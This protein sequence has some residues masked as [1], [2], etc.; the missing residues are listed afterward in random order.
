MTAVAAVLGA[1]FL[2]ATL[3]VQAFALYALLLA[4]LGTPRRASRVRPIPPE[5]TLPKIAALLVAHDE[6]RVIGSAV[7][8]LVAQAYPA[9]RFDV[10]LVADHCSDETATIAMSKGATAFLRD[11]GTGGKAFAVAFGVDAII[12]RGGF[13]AIAVFDADNLAVPAFMAAAGARIAAGERVVQGF[14]DSKNPAASW[15][16]ASS[17]LGFWALAALAQTPRE[18]LRLQTPLMGT[19]FVICLDEAARFLRDAESLTDDLELGARLALAGVRV[20]YERHARTI[21]EKPVSLDTAVK[22][23]HR[24]MQGRFSVAERYLPALLVEALSG[25]T[26]PLAFRLR[27]FDAAVQLVAPSLLFTAVASASMVACGKALAWVLPDTFA[28][29]A[30]WVPARWSLSLA[31]LS[32]VVPAL[33]IA[34]YKPPLAVWPYYLLQSVYLALSLPLAVSGWLGR[35]GK[36]WKRTPKGA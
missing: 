7:E 19:G 13:D 33:G 1:T 36:V 34:K 35:N 20:A 15:V 28:Q 10:F 9:D 32:F 23:R 17:A 21:D 31:A 2:T 8:H 3:V 12:R 24:W 26:K 27:L 5:D 14:V 18:F 30:F 25:E 22:Q 29:V 4:A 16:A 6:E 11:A